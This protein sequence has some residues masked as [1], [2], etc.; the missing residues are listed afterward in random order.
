MFAIS[1]FTPQPG[2]IKSVVKYSKYNY[3]NK[4]AIPCI[5]FQTPILL[6]ELQLCFNNNK[7]LDLP[8]QKIIEF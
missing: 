6:K 1:I 2:G 3:F 8:Y 5:Y 4:C 7:K